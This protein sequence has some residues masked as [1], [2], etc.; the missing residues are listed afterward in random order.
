MTSVTC[1]PLNVLTLLGQ[2]PRQELQQD[3]VEVAA[4]LQVN[5]LPFQPLA[6]LDHLRLIERNNYVKT[7]SCLRASS[8]SLVQDVRNIGSSASGTVSAKLSG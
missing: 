5:A 1:T 8:L 4:G 2:L 3:S 7:S 6:M